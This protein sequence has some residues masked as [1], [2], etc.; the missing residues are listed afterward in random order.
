MY[1]DG[2]VHLYRR[3]DVQRLLTT[4]CRNMREAARATGQPAHY[5]LLLVADP[6]GVPG[7]EWIAS[8]PASS[9]VRHGEPRWRCFSQP[10]SSTVHLR[11]GGGLPVAVVGGKQIVS[12]ENLEVLAFPSHVDCAQGEPIADV[13]AGVQRQGGLA[14]LPWGVGKWLGK[15]AG[16]I[17]RMLDDA[18]PGSVAVGD[19]GGR[20]GAWRRVGLLREAAS[21]GFVNIAGTDPLPVEG[22]VDRVGSFGV[23]TPAS[24]DETWGF[25]AFRRALLDGRLLPFGGLLGPLDFLRKQLALRARPLGPSPQRA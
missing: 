5:G 15:R 14:I 20:P 6:A 17:T 9:G 1:V 12:A 16:I 25:E 13:L 19:N 21:A 11:D 3:E 7:F 22:E 24:P 10:D 2:H 8:L 18:D 23:R 4:A